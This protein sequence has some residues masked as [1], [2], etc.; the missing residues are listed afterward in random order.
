MT[1]NDQQKD[2]ARS[3][4][5]LQNNRLAYIDN[6]KVLAIIFVVIIHVSTTY[7]G[8]GSWYYTEHT[9]LDSTSFYFFLSVE[10]WNLAYLMPMF[11][12]IAAYFVSPSL[13]KKGVKRF[14]Q[15]RLFRLGAPT[16]IYTLL[17]SPFVIKIGHPNIDLLGFYKK[18]LASFSFISWTGPMW[19]ALTLLIFSIMYIPLNQLFIKLANRYSFTLNIKTALWLIVINGMSAFAIRLIYP[20]GT[21]VINLQFC[22]FAVYISMFLAGIIAYRKSILENI[23]YSMA[24][25]W[26]LTALT[27]G[28]PLWIVVVYYG[29]NK[30]GLQY[31]AILGGW[32]FLALGYALWES[33][34]CVAIIIG[35]IGIFKKRFN[36]QNTLQKFLSDNAFGVYVFHP[37]V[38]VTTSI[39]LKNVSIYPILKFVVVV[40]ITVPLSFIFAALI[41]KV[42]ILQKLFS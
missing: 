22:F 13:D 34:F 29:V 24:K 30:T 3:A 5:V 15:D 33:F 41:R 20:I 7:S 11:F 9:L 31:S 18:G 6:L 26:F 36:T 28:I 23:N 27:L 25:K 35:L 17:I 2:S 1:S 12:L 16:L 40:F 21:S 19:F 14:I 32:N 8:F 38:V 37:V 4:G 39:L 10:L 42:R